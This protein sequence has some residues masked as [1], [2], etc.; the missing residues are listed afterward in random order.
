[1][2]FFK[3]D[4]EFY[5]GNFTLMPEINPDALEPLLSMLDYDDH[6]D[7]V[8]RPAGSTYRRDD[9]ICN[10]SAGEVEV[11]IND[12]GC[13]L[14]GVTQILNYHWVGV[15]PPQLNTW[16]TE[17]HGYAGNGRVIPRKVAEYARKVHQVGV[18][19]LGFGY[20]TDQ[21]EELVYDY[22][23]QL[24]GVNGGSHFVVGTGKNPER[25]RTKI[26][27]TAGGLWATIDSMDVLRPFRGEHDVYT[28]NSGITICFYSPGELLIENPEGLKTGYDPINGLYYNEIPRSAYEALVGINSHKYPIPVDQIPKTEMLDISEPFDGDY[29]LYVI[30]TETGTYDLDIITWDSE[31]NSST[32]SFREIPITPGETHTYSYNYSKTGGSDIEI[33][34]DG[35]GQRPRDVNKF[36]SYVRPSQ[37][38]TSLPAG[39]TTYNSIIVYG[40]SIIPSSFKAE[41][42]GL[43]ITSLFNPIPE[44]TDAVTL[45]L[46]QGRNKLI[47]SVDANLTNR[48]ANDKDT[49]LFMVP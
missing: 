5:S 15:T 29:N 19:F 26:I 24:V 45:N 25:T 11:E 10:G 38:Q 47:L 1:M 6:Y 22:G 33:G 30:G 43:D 49:L 41:L 7:N 40:D 21:L 32:N 13:Y 3:D 35:S 48:V 14:T 23:P 36:L 37:R 12:E 16:L 28:D 18:K 39:T 2:K 8:C 44:G 20:S 31:L 4:Q 42:N 17:N 46:N 34:Y 9:Y 27:E